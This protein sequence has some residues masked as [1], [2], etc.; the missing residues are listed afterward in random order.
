MSSSTDATP[1]L[2]EANPIMRPVARFSTTVSVWPD[3]AKYDTVVT[4]LLTCI[5]AY[6]FSF[7]DAPSAFLPA[8]RQ[9]TSPSQLG[10][11]GRYDFQD[12]WGHH[13]RGRISFGFRQFGNDRLDFRIADTSEFAQS[14]GA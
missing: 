13:H 14:L 3:T 9:V 8:Q 10:M 5:A 7:A 12:Q 11:L 4:S 2:F 1:V 6:R